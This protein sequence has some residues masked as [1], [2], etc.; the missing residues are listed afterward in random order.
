MKKLRLLILMSF[1]ACAI[2]ALAACTTT[3][4]ARPGGLRVDDYA[5][6]L[7]WMPVT[8]A[9]GY[10]VELDGNEVADAVIGTEYTFTGLSVG[11]H[12][13]R[14]QAISRTSGL[15]D[16]QWSREFTFHKYRETGM[17]YKLI[18]SRTEYEL[19]GIGTNT[20]EVVV[21]STYHGLPVTSIG[22]S[23]FAANSRVTS[24]V[25]EEG[26][27]T[28]GTR[29]F[30]TCRALVS[31][32]LPESLESIG[33]NAFQNCI[34]LE[35]IDIPSGVTSI[36][37]S[38]F[39][40]CN[41]ATSLTI[42]ENVTEVGE[43]AF[44]GCTSLTSVELPDKLVTLGKSAFMDCTSLESVTI[45]EKVEALLDSTFQGCSALTD[46]DMSGATSLE[47]LGNYVFRYCVALENC[48]LS[49]SVTEIGERVFYGCT[50]LNN[51]DLGEGME[52]V[53]RRSFEETAIWEKA[54]GADGVVYVDHWIVGC[55]K[56]DM[57]QVTIKPDT[58]G[59]GVAAF[60]TAAELEF[61]DSD[62]D[63]MDLKV[64][65][66]RNLHLSKIISGNALESIEIPDS[67]RFINERAFRHCVYLTTVKIGKSVEKLGKYAFANC[68]SLTQVTFA[69]N[70]VLD[71]ID[72]YCFQRCISFGRSTG[73]TVWASTFD[74]P[75]SLTY[76]G[77]HTFYCTA[78]WMDTYSD[79]ADCGQGL[80]YAPD[81]EGGWFQ[82]FPP[83]IVDHWAVEFCD[84]MDKY[85]QDQIV[86]KYGDE[87]D[88]LGR[89]A[90][91]PEGVVGICNYGFYNHHALRGVVSSN[92]VQG[93]S[94]EKE[95]ET[96]YIP[97]SVK[98]I[99]P[100]AFYGCLDIRGKLTIPEGVETIE[101]YAFYNC[102]HITALEIPNT[103][104]D[105]QRS[106]F[107]GC[108]EIYMLNLPDSVTEI[109]DYSFCKCEGITNLTIGDHITYIGARAFSQCKELRSL[110]LE[111]EAPEGMRIMTNAFS[112]C[113]NL[114]VAI[115]A[116]GVVEIGPYAFSNCAALESVTMTDSVKTIGNSAFRLCSA[117]SDIR[118]SD[119][120]ES[121]GVS[122]FMNCTS[123]TNIALP[124][125][126][127]SIEKYAFLG[128]ASLL[129]VTLPKSVSRIA[130]HAFLNCHELT[131][132]TQ[133]ESKPSGWLQYYNTSARPIFWGCVFSDDGTYVVSFIKSSENSSYLNDKYIISEPYREGYEFGGWITPTDEIYSGFDVNLVKDN[134]Y[135]E[136]IW[137]IAD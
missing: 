6:E 105:I 55:T 72:D 12:T 132:F 111:T 48:S 127:V 43:S 114:T 98:Y 42:G 60:Y 86:A 38:A 9:A 121:I 20:G 136:A 106:A 52:V 25:I 58:V 16:S 74:F 57:K 100:A 70:S 96:F 47:Y 103:V 71:T 22:D 44:L 78:L 108:K 29:A 82:K 76:I 7:T 89:Y 46:V 116:D 130:N 8:S 80:N 90:Y 49:D 102:R 30:Q 75:D 69:E 54:D 4:L 92:E 56:F 122:A 34:R 59:I 117:L 65:V 81:G 41:A 28:I 104:K 67:V 118:L 99:G 120:I 84:T 26:I 2:M 17:I 83:L 124:S 93:G 62:I 11:D 15:S 126:L 1:V 50:L 107:Y 119:S 21:E 13:V 85:N 88:Y 77:Y 35:E 32:K 129:S 63:I 95:C 40:Y 112:D 68:V 113:D 14:V 87:V 64:N 123:L 37:N 125:S 45:G 79:G 53:C 73:S 39:A 109:G 128:C 115:L 134:T 94:T 131:I 137:E 135:L 51:V 3:G 133:W 33:D 91:I 5:T 61:S 101:P 66:E 36:G 18:N 97:S 110:Y 10:R 27:K 19:T 24:V 23:A 31:V